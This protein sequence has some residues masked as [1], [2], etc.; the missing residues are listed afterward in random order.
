MDR[1]LKNNYILSNKTSINKGKNTYNRQTCNQK[2]IN[3]LESS[4]RKDA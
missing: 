3:Q 1:D 4:K 2:E